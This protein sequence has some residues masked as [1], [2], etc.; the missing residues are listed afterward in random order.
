MDKTRAIDNPRGRFFEIR[1]SYLIMIAISLLCVFFEKV[2][3]Y[4]FRIVRM[5]SIS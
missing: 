4:Y 5:D 3:R 2:R 1:G